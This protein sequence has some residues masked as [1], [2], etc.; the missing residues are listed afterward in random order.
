MVSIF[1]GGL[2]IV[3]NGDVDSFTPRLLVAAT[4]CTYVASLVF[5][6]AVHK[7]IPSKVIASLQIVCDLVLVTLVVYVTGGIGSAL[8]FLYGIIIIL[9]TLFVGPRWTL[10]TAMAALF[11]YASLGFALASEALPIPPDQSPALYELRS[12]ELAFAALSNCLGLSLVAVLAGSLSY[13][14][15]RAGGALRQATADVK[16]LERLNDNIVRS[17]RSGLL[18]TSLDGRVEMINEAGL[19]MFATDQ[20]C[21]VGASLREILPEAHQP[22]QD[23]PRGEGLAQSPN[24]HR[25]PVGFT[26]TPLLDGQ[27]ASTGQLISFQDLTQVR[28]LKQQAEKAEKLAALGRLAAGL[29]HEVRNPLGAIRGCVELVRDGLHVSN[30]DRQLLSTV[31]REVD[32]LDDLV[33]TILYAGRPSPP[34][35]RITNLTQLSAEVVEMTRK[36]ITFPGT[37]ACTSQSGHS[38]EVWAR[39]DGDQ[40]RQVLWNLIKNAIQASSSGG[41]VLVEAFYDDAVPSVRISDE[42]EGIEESTKERLFETYHS[43]RPHGMGLGLTIVKQIIDAHGAT[44]DIRSE[45][46][47]GSEFTIQ[48]QPAN[49]ECSGADRQDTSRQVYSGLGLG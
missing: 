15:S 35:A 25:F 44:I 49:T 30:E 21:L 11:L 48:F 2:F 27:G 26:K 40:M 31:L 37:V 34:D 6:F 24:G 7:G 3:S 12:G 41:R 19:E 16:K 20:K 4:T 43:T 46:G 33:G 29:A 13:R 9:G 18:T 47:K 22:L 28:E 17:I 45:P 5:T 10:Y 8:T 39:V 32:R 36:G 23:Q 1:L 14:L 38:A 42:G